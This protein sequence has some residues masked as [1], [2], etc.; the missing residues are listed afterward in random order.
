MYPY[1]KKLKNGSTITSFPGMHNTAEYSVLLH[2]YYETHDEAE[3]IAV[4]PAARIT[5]EIK[6]FLVENTGK[7]IPLMI[8]ILQKNHQ[9]HPAAEND[10]SILQKVYDPLIKN[11]PAAALKSF[12]GF[13]S[14]SILPISPV[15]SIVEAIRI[16]VEKKIEVTGL[17]LLCLPPMRFPE[18]GICVQDFRGTDLNEYIARI[19]KIS[20]LMKDTPVDNIRDIVMA[21]NLQ[22]LANQY[23]HICYVGGMGHFQA[24]MDLLDD[25]ELNAE[26]IAEATKSIFDS[27]RIELKRVI[28]DPSLVLQICNRTLPDILAKY[29]IC[30]VPVS[31]GESDFSEVLHPDIHMQKTLKKISSLYVSQGGA[32]MTC[33]KFQGEIFRRASVSA[34][35]LPAT[36]DIL[37]VAA[38][39]ERL[40]RIVYKEFL[41][42]FND[43]IYQYG[44]DTLCPDLNSNDIAINVIQT[45]S[46]QAHNVTINGLDNRELR[47]VYAEMSKSR[48]DF[49]SQKD[50]GQKSNIFSEHWCYN[51]TDIYALAYRAILYSNES[52]Q[53]SVKI[54]SNCSVAGPIDIRKTALSRKMEPFSNVYIKPTLSREEEDILDG[55]NPDPCVVVFEEDNDISYYYQIYC[56]GNN[57]GE[58]F[59]NPEKYTNIIEKQGRFF[60]A[61]IHICKYNSAPEKIWKYGGEIAVTKAAVLFGDPVVNKISGAM[62]IE[63][64]C[65]AGFPILPAVTMPD[66]YRFYREKK[67]VELEFNDRIMTLI[68]AAIGMAKKSVTI[69]TAIPLQLQ[70]VKPIAAKRNIQIN[71]VPLSL[72]EGGNLG[73]AR[74]RYWF[75]IASSDAVLFSPELEVLTGFKPND[76]LD[77]L[78]PV[79]KRRIEISRLINDGGG[80]ANGLSNL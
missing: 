72:F 51:E 58:Y 65:F 79:A 31:E 32:P 27:P 80:R 24:I 48:S 69:V 34:N 41:Q 61:S 14:D 43:D 17:D 62:A 55:T 63:A 70:L 9:F 71:V 8:G 53:K 12:A 76:Q 2:K 64:G 21:A 44:Y 78:A 66:L 13:Y 54:S 10:V 47:E 28:L 33:E 68:A 23:K 6:K 67:N 25:N 52:S 20:P 4:E 45:G 30:R 59:T 40:L 35:T 1:C 7:P 49:N 15:D 11:I 26:K 39:D 74:N 5:E 46:N 36:I 75:P 37:R 42:P 73:N 60:V 29:E 57:L 19:N 77:R 56:S 16:G 22:M 50:A 38:M 3:V 18:D